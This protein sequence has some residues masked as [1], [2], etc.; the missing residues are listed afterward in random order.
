MKL[1]A[2][3]RVPVA[4]NW[5]Q[6]ARL[7]DQLDDTL[8]NLASALAGVASGG[9]DPQPLVR[10]FYMLDLTVSA[11]TQPHPRP[12]RNWAR[13]VGLAVE[14]LRDA[15]DLFVEAL[16]APTALA[17]QAAGR[18][19]QS[20][21]D[22]AQERLDDLAEYRKYAS[23][24]DDD[25]G[26]FIEQLMTSNRLE[27]SSS[28]LM[29]LD[30]ALRERHGLSSGATSGAG[31]E[32]DLYRP[33]VVLAL[34]QDRVAQIVP[35][36]ERTLGSDRVRS[37]A[38][39]DVWAEEHGRVVAL[40]SAMLA[41]TFT[42]IADRSELQTV[43][44]LLDM[45]LKLKEGHLKHLLATVL[46]VSDAG[47]YEA[48]LSASTGMV[49][50]SA[51]AQFPELQLGTLNRTLRNAAGHSAFNVDESGVT[52]RENGAPRTFPVADFL[53][54]VLEY[55]ELSIILQVGL[56]RA[57]AEFGVEIP[58]SRHLSNSDRRMAIRTFAAS[59][60][61]ENIA[62]TDLAPV[63]RIS[64]QGPS[65]VFARLGSALVNLLPQDA[66]M[67][68]VEL[69][70]GERV[71]RCEVDLVR[72]RN[73][74][75]TEDVLTVRGALQMAHIAA[76]HQ[77]DGSTAS[78]P[79]EWSSFAHAIALDETATEIQRLRGLRQL[80][81]LA[82]ECGVGGLLRVVEVHQTRLRKKLE[83]RVPER[84]GNSFVRS[85]AK[86]SGAAF[87]SLHP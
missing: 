75:I 31:M 78:S 45:V 5:S 43:S 76:A 16:I 84:P 34:D 69:T 50:K 9:N 18:R 51:E 24:D 3:Q 71:R 79:D 47:N 23:F 55:L 62:V 19:A 67:L 65:A 35:Q 52:V 44:E 77:V 83:H 6:A 68:H 73:S 13:T 8:D 38:L 63:T 36:V 81:A 39:H 41:R 27:S 72:L 86:L 56:V 42:G 59:I 80:R 11:W 87:R 25:V 17:A 70:D 2:E 20:A 12:R 49:F 33:I 37:L 32:L 4:A 58:A 15:G 48:L 22:Q 1:F 61:W 64:A 54:D 26:V 21:F 30:A 53:N 82:E 7:R 40:L 57:C 14:S 74:R 28:S 66:E 85:E 60:G 46:H 10:A 29:E